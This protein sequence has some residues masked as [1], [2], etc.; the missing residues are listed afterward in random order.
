MER[1]ILSIRCGTLEAHLDRIEQASDTQERSRRAID[2]SG[3]ADKV[4][5]LTP[6]S[7]FSEDEYQTLESNLEHIALAVFIENLDW[8]RQSLNNVKEL[9]R[10]LF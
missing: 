4:L 1:V 10:E 3:L 5:S 8:A 9:T 2:L 7:A 6:K